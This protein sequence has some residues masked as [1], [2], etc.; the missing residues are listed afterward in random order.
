MKVEIIGK[1]LDNHFHEVV[2]RYYIFTIDDLFEDR[3]KDRAAVHVEIDS[4]DL[5]ESDKVGTD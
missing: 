1:D 2:L 4:F 5:R 3:R